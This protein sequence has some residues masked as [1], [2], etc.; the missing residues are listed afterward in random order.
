MARLQ[1]NIFVEWQLGRKIFWA[2]SPSPRGRCE[3]RRRHAIH[4]RER[5]AAP[6]RLR[7]SLLASRVPWRFHVACRGASATL[8][9]DRLPQRVVSRS[10]LSPSLPIFAGLLQLE[11]RRHEVRRAVALPTD[12]GDRNRGS[13]AGRRRVRRAAHCDRQSPRS[14]HRAPSRA[15]LCTLL[16]AYGVVV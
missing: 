6:R 12:S 7:A 1:Q 11:H 3:G 5:A 15:P 2:R 14:R 9:V 16:Q 13:S 10:S 4:L 8:R